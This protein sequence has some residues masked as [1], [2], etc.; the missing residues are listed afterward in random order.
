MSSF[1]FLP[2]EVIFMKQHQRQLKKFSDS[3][4]EAINCLSPDELE[5]NRIIQSAR[6]SGYICPICSSG[7]GSHGTG[8]TQNP[9]IENHTSLHCFGCGKSFNPLQLCTLHY[10]LEFRRN[11]PDLMEKICADFNIPIEYEDF[12]FHSSFRG[13]SRKPRKLPPLDAKELKNIQADLN[14]STDSLKTFMKYQPDQKWRGFD[15]EFL[16]AHGCRLI[17]DW[18]PPSLRD[19]NQQPSKN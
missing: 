7:D 13:S 18:F 2:H 6:V 10:G 14:A 11:F 3:T 8:M 1:F 19:T 4:L 5:T 12:A 17:N 9:K 16:I 15:L